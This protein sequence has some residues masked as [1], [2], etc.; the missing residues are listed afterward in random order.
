MAVA[1]LACA[2]PGRGHSLDSGR[3]TSR[4]P[5]P[6]ACIQ[7]VQGRPASVELSL[8]VFR[9]AGIEP[10]ERPQFPEIKPQCPAI[11]IPVV[12]SRQGSAT[13]PTTH[14]VATN[15]RG[16]GRLRHIALP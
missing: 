5:R 15:L 14:C 6:L 9:S 10:A 11:L 13:A 8:G 16:P 1:H 2:K 3:C 4:A 7:P 12:T